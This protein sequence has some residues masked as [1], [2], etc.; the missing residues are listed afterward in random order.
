MQTYKNRIY[1]VLFVIITLCCL[2]S[3]SA[4]ADSISVV[5][6]ARLNMR[7]RPSTKGRIIYV[8]PKGDTIRAASVAEDGWYAASCKGKNGY[9]SAKYVLPVQIEEHREIPKKDYSFWEK[10]FGFLINVVLGCIGI[11]I[12]L[13]ILYYVF[14]FLAGMLG[15][16]SWLFTI[17]FRISTI[18]LL[19]TNNVQRILEKPWIWFYKSNGGNDGRNEFARRFWD[20]VKIPL[21]IGLTPLRFVNAVAYN[22]CIHVPFEMFNYVIEVLFP[23]HKSEGRGNIFKWLLFIPWRIVKYPLWH[24]L[25][26]FV[27]SLVWTIIDTF[28]PA[29]TL[30]HGTSMGS[31]ESIV[32]SPDRY[33]GDNLKNV[34]VWCVGTGNYAGDGIYFAPSRRTAEHY[35]GGGSLIVCRVSPGTTLDL[36]MA[37]FHVFAQCGHPN[38]HGV[39]AWALK[40][41][42]TTGLW[43][44]D[45]CDWWEY[46]MY[47]WK[48]RYNYSWRI[49]PLYVIC[50]ENGLIQRIPGG[51]SHWLFRDLVVKDIL[52]G[53]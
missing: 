8:I 37:P 30:Y 3:I 16:L 33:T 9:V 34:G 26:T 42:F 47:D 52:S 19:I 41:G 10:A 21:Y 36:G 39:T 53:I 40:N 12:V 23:G 14:L 35:S 31:A 13:F 43:W 22:L 17:A 51:M 24:G 44:R 7:S 29:L 5:T 28:V 50:L 38:A 11:G 15:F 27:E 6:T 18:P 49:R 20:I 45:D 1:I 48:N 2:P 32:R 46:C 25:L 4:M